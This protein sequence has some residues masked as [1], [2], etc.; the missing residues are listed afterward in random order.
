MANL[1]SDGGRVFLIGMMGSG[2]TTVGRLLA[3]RLAVPFVDLDQAIEQRTGQTV[4]EVF[5]QHGEFNFRAC[6]AQVLRDLPRRYPTAVIATGGGAP[7]HFDNVDFMRRTG[8]VVYLQAS[9]AELIRRLTSKR[10]E[11]PLLRREDWKDFIAGLIEDREEAYGKAH[12]SYGVD[13]QTVDETLEG[14]LRDL[15]QVMGH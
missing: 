13:A 12:A 1:L 11:R 5:E 6:E 8:T 14:L 7:V 2:K 4:A 10:K 9:A 3:E 15:G